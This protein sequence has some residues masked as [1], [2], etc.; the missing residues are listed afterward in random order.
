M[1]GHT[2]N[3]RLT[4]QDKTLLITGSTLEA[5]QTVEH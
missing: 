1:N 4:K 2:P 5:W 3:S